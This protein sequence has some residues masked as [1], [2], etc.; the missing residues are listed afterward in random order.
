MRN[1]F[2]KLCKL[3]GGRLMKVKKFVTM[4]IIFLFLAIA[5][6]GCET[7]RASFSREYR[8]EHKD[9]VFFEVPEVFELCNIAIAITDYGLN[10]PNRIFKNSEYYKRVIQHFIPYKSHPFIKEIENTSFNDYNALINSG[11]VYV[12]EENSIVKGSIYE[13]VYKINVFLERANLIE[14]FVRV[15]GFRDFYRDNYEYYQEQIE[16]YQVKLPVMEMWKWLEVQFP[17]KFD[18]YK[19][20]FSPLLGSSHNT[21]S[22]NHLGFK[23]CVMVVSSSEYYAYIKDGDLEKALLSKLVFTEIDHNYVN[24]VTDKYRSKVNKALNVLKEWNSQ[25]GY[26]SSYLTFNEYLTWGVF[27]LYA[28]DYYDETKYK[29]IESEVIRIMHNRGFHRFQEF[30]S[31]LLEL[32][33]DR[34]N[35][36]AELFPEIIEWFNTN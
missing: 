24:R 5:L 14:D 31:F 3:L 34:K 25:S 36:V 13:N 35:T 4:L 17:Q 9:K 29:I 10:D 18:S 6:L 33:I 23:E 2:E 28:H 15:S 12:F 22:F 8:I 11:L 20:V 30:N 16:K 32:Y 26:Q 1:T 21:F 7:F 27:N 19:V